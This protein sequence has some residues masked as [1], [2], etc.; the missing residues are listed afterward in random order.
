MDI[1]EE[2]V[3]SAQMSVSK[4]VH[5]ATSKTT[6]LSILRLAR[7]EFFPA[8]FVEVPIHWNAVPCILD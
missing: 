3:A 4:D 6:E 2:R 1:S 5:D 7:F 8:V